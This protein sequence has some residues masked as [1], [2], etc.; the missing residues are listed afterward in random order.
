MD[1]MIVRVCLFMERNDSM[2]IGKAANDLPL[3]LKMRSCYC[4]SKV[5]GTKHRSE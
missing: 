1:E 2:K 5:K 3:A 4:D